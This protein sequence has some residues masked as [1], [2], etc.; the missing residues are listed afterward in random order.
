MTLTL[1]TDT[2]F[3]MLNMPGFKNSPY[4][5]LINLETGP[6]QSF[7]ATKIEYRAKNDSFNERN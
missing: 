1:R 7:W 2:N 5:P 4:S 6:N 3:T